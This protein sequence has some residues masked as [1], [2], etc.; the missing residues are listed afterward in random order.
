MERRYRLVHSSRFRQVYR[1]GRSLVHPLLVLRAL[2]NGLPYSRFGFVVSKRIGK[3]VE[4]NRVKRLMREAMRAKRADVPCGLDVVLI[5]R[6]PIV[7]VA[8]QDIR[9]ALERLV[10]L[11]V[12][13]DPAGSHG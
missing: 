7:H 5:A 12:A 4:R 9:E 3:A 10:P 1:D 8:F 13:L 6:T 11:R 2:D